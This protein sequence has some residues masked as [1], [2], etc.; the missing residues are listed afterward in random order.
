MQRGTLFAGLAAEGRRDVRSQA[1]AYDRFGDRQQRLWIALGLL[2]DSR[3]SAMRGH[4]HARRGLTP[5]QT[6]LPMRRSGRTSVGESTDL[7]GTSALTSGEP[8]AK[9]YWIAVYH[10]VSDPAAVA[11]YAEA[12]TPVLKSFGAC[13]LAR[14]MPACVFEGGANQRCVVIEFPSVEQ[15]VAA[16]NSEPYQRALAIMRGAVKREVRIV[17]GSG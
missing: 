7:R 17:Q 16:Y 2:L 4:T 9:G 13:F 12:A 6:C 8:M 5:K 3:E 1:N 10:S 14:G 11:S 15:A